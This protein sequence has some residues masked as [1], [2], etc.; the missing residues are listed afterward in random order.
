MRPARDYHPTVTTPVRP[1]SPG[2]LSTPHWCGECHR[3]MRLTADGRRCAKCNPLYGRD[4]PLGGTRPWCGVCDKVDRHVHSTTGIRRCRACHPLGRPP[5]QWPMFDIP[6]GRTEQLLACDW[7][8]HISPMMFKIRTEELRELFRPWFD[9]GW[10]PRDIVYA[11]DHQP[12]GEAQFGDN[13]SGKVTAKL[14]INFMKRRLRA[15]WPDEDLKPFPAINQHIAH[16][17]EANLAALRERRAGW[18][19]TARTAT[20]AAESVAAA[21]ARII[22]QRAAANAAV[23][24]REGE[25]RERARL[26]A[27]IEDRKRSVSEWAERLETLA[28][29][30]QVS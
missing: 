27:D 23:L 24:R 2:T 11:L 20:P 6:T 7:L 8:R 12:T 25:A 21:Q 22:A 17:R 28:T 4:E 30:G 5:E 15:W 9:A 10:T 26:V 13:P 16:N 1:D 14:V 29:T 19:A 18:D 3:S